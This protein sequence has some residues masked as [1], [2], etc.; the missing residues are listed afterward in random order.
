MAAAND[1]IENGYRMGESTAPYHINLSQADRWCEAVNN[2]SPVKTN[3]HSPAIHGNDTHNR[4]VA[5]KPHIHSAARH[6]IKQI[7]TVNGRW[8]PST[9]SEMFYHF[10]W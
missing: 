3:V 7:A 10:A 6:G 9:R 8:S 1:I 2:A 4:A 5:R